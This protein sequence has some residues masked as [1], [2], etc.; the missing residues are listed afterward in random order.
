MFPEGIM[1]KGLSQPPLR[2]LMPRPIAIPRPRIMPRPFI[3][4]RPRIEKDMKQP[5]NNNR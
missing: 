1:I 5:K 2:S 3:M 4:A